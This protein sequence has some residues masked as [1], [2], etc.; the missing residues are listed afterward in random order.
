MRYKRRKTD[1]RHIVLM[2]QFNGRP[3][4]KWKNQILKN[5]IMQKRNACFWRPVF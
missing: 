2:T 1:R 4:T 5:S 3:K